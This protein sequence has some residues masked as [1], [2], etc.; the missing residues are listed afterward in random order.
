MSN[1]VTSQTKSWCFTTNNYAPTEPISTIE[2]LR[3]SALL[4]VIGKEIAPEQEHHLQGYVQFKQRKRFS[5]VKAILPTGS[6]IE[7]AKG[8]PKQNLDI[9]LSQATTSP[10]AHSQLE[11]IRLSIWC[12]KT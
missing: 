11:N 8:S 1:K 4:A 12:V 3:E 5:Q 6:H 9:V 7:P 10:S 2:R